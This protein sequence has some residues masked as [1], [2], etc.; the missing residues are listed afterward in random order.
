MAKDKKQQ[1]NTCIYT[2]II[3]NSIFLCLIYIL[4]YKY[5]IG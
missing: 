1:Q 3:Q 5:Y 2:Y 4:T